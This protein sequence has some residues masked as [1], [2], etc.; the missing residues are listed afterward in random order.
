MILLLPNS[1]SW[2]SF[3]S[4]HLSLSPFLPLH[5][6]SLHLL[7][8]F[9]YFSHTFPQYP[10]PLILILTFLSIVP[11]H[12]YPSVHSPLPFCSLR[13]PLLQHPFSL[14][15]LSFLIPLSFP[16]SPVSSLSSHLSLL[17][18]HPPPLSTSLISFPLPT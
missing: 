1:S 2:V 13:I 3:P 9:T 15:F 12:S 14:S 7:Y 18:S 17:I 10:S 4:P 6:H 5:S 16:L 8:P 11:L